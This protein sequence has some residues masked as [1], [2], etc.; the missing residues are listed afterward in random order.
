MVDQ[1]NESPFSITFFFIYKRRSC[2]KRLSLV[3]NHNNVMFVW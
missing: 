3:F 1:F 2:L